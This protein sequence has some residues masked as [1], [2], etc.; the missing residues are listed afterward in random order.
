M[1]FL[2]NLMAGIAATM[3]VGV[4]SA[5]DLAPDALVKATASDVL[6]IIKKDKDIQSG[7]MRKISALAEEKI[8]PH[9]DF[10]RMS[11]MVL[12]KHW[13][14]ATKEQQQQFIAEFRS[15]LIRTYASAL[16]KYRNQTIEYKP[17]RAQPSDTEVTVKT[18]IV[19]PGG[20]PL[21]IDYSLVKKEDGWKV[22]DVA[23]EG[24]SLVTNYRGQFSTEVRQSGM[25]GLIQRLA[26][27]NKQ[28]SV[29]TAADRKQ[30]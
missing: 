23:I 28:G 21:P 13:S 4:A 18:Q 7:D 10:E 8:L 19:Q 1:K 5:S 29:S 22:Y 15:L 17:F 14:R 2:I 26:E 25:D 9:F 27:K 20:Q 12:G 11:R 30:G 16:T 24:V 3:L 6:D